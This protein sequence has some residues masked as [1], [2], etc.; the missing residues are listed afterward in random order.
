MSRPPRIHDPVQGSLNEPLAAIADE[1]K[2]E[3]QTIAARP[4]VKWVGG[5][6]SILPELVRRMPRQ[7]GAYR[8]AFVGGGA[9]FFAVQPSRAYLSDINF[10]LILTYR[11]VRDDVQ[12]LIAL[13]K[14]H[15]KNHSLDYFKK[16]RKRVCA[17]QD[18]TA[19]AALLIYLNKTCFNGLYRVNKQGEFNVPMGSYKDPGIFD[20]S[21][22]RNDSTLLQGVDLFQHPFWQVPLVREDFYYLDPPYH[23]TY[24]Q[25]DGRGF[26]DEAHRKLATF[27]N[28][29]NDAKAYFMLSNADTPFVRSLYEGFHFDRV[30][31]A[32]SVSCNGAERGR[33]NELIIRN[34]Q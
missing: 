32:R 23:Q 22:L 6:R 28:E 31:G 18:A 3:T 12:K 20:E 34:Y 8:E 16:A 5:K 17:E 7:Y 24:S 25:Y 2:P 13:L 30:A 1:Q 4:F 10:H 19:V 15:E 14:T 26:D 27:C 21:V 29:L 9:L 11:A 33:E